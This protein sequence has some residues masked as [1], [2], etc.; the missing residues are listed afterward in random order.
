MRIIKNEALIKRNSR[1]GQWTSPGALTCLHG[2]YLLSRP[3]PF[4]YSIGM[5]RVSPHP[6]RVLRSIRRSRVR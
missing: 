2:T 6:G 3:D 5:I 1:V 4:A